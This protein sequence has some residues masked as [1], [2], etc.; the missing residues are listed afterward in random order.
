MAVKIEF[1]SVIVPVRTIEERFHGGMDGFKEE[2]GEPPTDGRLVRM[3]A[4]NQLDLLTI[5]HALERGGL[6]KTFYKDR[7]EHWLD[8][9]VVDRFVGPTLPCEWIEVDLEIGEARMIDRDR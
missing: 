4:M 1:L 9:C 3:G 6:K 2:C 7:R 8:L 5:I